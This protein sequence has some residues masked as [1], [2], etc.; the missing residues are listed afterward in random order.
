MLQSFSLLLRNLHFH[1]DARYAPKHIAVKMPLIMLEIMVLVAPELLM[2]SNGLPPPLPTLPERCD[3]ASAGETLVLLV[4]LATVFEDVSTTIPVVVLLVGTGIFDVVGGGD[5]TLDCLEVRSV[6]LL[7]IIGILESVS[8]P[9][10][11]VGNEESIMVLLPME[12]VLLIEIV[13]GT[14]PL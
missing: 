5:A 13:I 4:E 2:L 14:A 9:D 11:T 12:A 10:V 1:P 7:G 6:V 8:I 3:S